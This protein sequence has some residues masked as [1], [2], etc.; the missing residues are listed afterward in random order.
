MRTIIGCCNRPAP[1]P[2]H[3]NC[4]FLILHNIMSKRSASDISCNDLEALDCLSSSRH[5]IL[6]TPHAY[7]DTTNHYIRK[8]FLGPIC[9]KC[10]TKVACYGTLFTISS[11]SILRH[12]KRGDCFIGNIKNLNA[13]ELEQ[14]LQMSIMQ[15]YNSIHQNPTLA[16]KIVTGQFH[17]NNISQSPYCSRCGYVGKSANVRRHIHTELSNCSSSDL[18][19]HGGKVLTDKYQFRIPQQ[20][21]DCISSGNFKLPFDRFTNRIISVNTTNDSDVHS[22]LSS[23]L[24]SSGQIPTLTILMTPAKYLPM[25]KEIKDICSPDSTCDNA[26]TINT[27]V[28]SELVH[29][30]GTVENATQAREFLTS[31]ILLIRQKYPGSLRSSLYKIGT[32][33]SSNSTDPNLK[34]LLTAGKIWLRSNNANIDVHMVPVHHRNA[35]YLVGNSFTEKD[36]DL[37]KGCTFVWSDSVDPIVEQ[38]KFLITYAYESQ[39]P[40]IQPY[41]DKVKQL[42]QLLLENNPMDLD[43]EEL[44]EL[45]STKI[46][47]STIICG[48]LSELLMEQPAQPNGPNCIYHYLAGV[49]VVPCTR[50]KSLSL[51]S[52]NGISRTA[53]AC[54]RL[55]RHGVCSF[56]V[57]QSV[58]MTQEMKSDADFQFWFNGFLHQMQVSSSVG[59]ICRT[60]RTARDVDRKSPSSVYK[61]F[62]DMTGDLVVDGNEIFKSSWSVAI[63]TACQEWDKHLIFLFPNHSSSS[64]ALPLQLFFN[65]K[66][67]IVLAE[68]DSCIYIDNSAESSIPLSEYQPNFPQ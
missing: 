52:A 12:W 60:I 25:D 19:L 43:I 27:F 51:R 42:Y 15:L 47:N 21:L 16:A 33:I 6:T 10:N 66:N 22:T 61:A 28:M 48:L 14:A 45:A 35:I 32:M 23:S 55:L 37:L 50:T 18:N 56:Y 11:K 4:L 3:H 36:K 39:W 62:N 40:I 46:V 67:H 44:E 63:P 9:T 34:L 54:L 1:G 53:N 68:E 20:V 24:S 26:T 29:C 13:K 59:H 38:F 30:F 65:L 58:L 17:S 5:S 2:L 31:F 7:R 64:S 57:R 41:L 8:T 49:C